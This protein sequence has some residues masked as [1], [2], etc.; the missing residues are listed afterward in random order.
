MRDRKAIVPGQRFARR[1]LAVGVDG[2]EMCR[3]GGLREGAAVETR[4]G[5]GYAAV[6]G[7]MDDGEIARIFSQDTQLRLAPS[8]VAMLLD[9][10]YRRSLRLE[11]TDQHPPVALDMSPSPAAAG[12][13]NASLQALR[14][15]PRPTRGGLGVGPGAGEP[16]V[17]PTRSEHSVARPHGKTS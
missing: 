10:P 3:C 13:P 4:G 7:V 6:E 16:H 2:K 1:M 11:R 8:V 9:H 17:L 15:Q 12:N 14:R 5:L